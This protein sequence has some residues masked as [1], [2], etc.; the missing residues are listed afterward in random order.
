MSNNGKSKNY[1]RKRLNSIILLLAFTAIMLIVSTYAW[2]SSQKNVTIKN[3]KGTVAVAEGLEI[4]L[5]AKDWLQVLDLDTVDWDTDSYDGNT[6]HI[7]SEFQPVST[8]GAGLGTA[9]DLTFYKGTLRNSV[10]LNNVITCDVGQ[11]DAT[12]NDYAGYYAF[13]IFLKNTTN[14]AVTTNDLQLNYD[15]YVKVLQSGDGLDSN[16]DDYADQLAALIAQRNATGL[17][18]TVRVAFGLYNGTAGTMDTQATILANTVTSATGN[19]L[20]STSIWEPNAASHIE[21]VLNAYN[22]DKPTTPITTATGTLTFGAE[23]IIPTFAL[24]TL[25][26]RQN[27][28][29]TNIYNWKADNA[30]LAEQIALQTNAVEGTYLIGTGVSQLITSATNAASG[31]WNTTVSA[32]SAKTSG[33]G[34][35]DTNK[36]GAVSNFSIPAN[37][38]C[39]MRVYVW[40]EGQDVDCLSVASHGGGVEVNLDIMKD[41]VLGSFTDAE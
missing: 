26:S 4:S 3:L 35:S 29:S 6:N 16:A 13:D 25:A 17:Q 21:S 23:D 30:D 18:N 41:G 19:I 14:G 31:K 9:K 38:V 7:P 27:N 39:R 12:E 5:N 22:G 10:N 40:L 28:N 32:T 20:D 24:K 33:A 34:D 1:T 15:S 37:A 2:F 8:D 36:E 11:T